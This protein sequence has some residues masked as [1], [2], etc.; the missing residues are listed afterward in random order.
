[1][2]GLGKIGGPQYQDGRGMLFAEPPRGP[3]GATMA[4]RRGQQK[5]Y[6]H[7]QGNA[8]YLAYREDALDAEGK[9]VRVRRN[10]RIADT[11]EVSKREAQRIAREILTRVDEQAQRPNS[12]VTVAEFIEGRFKPD[13]V[14]ALK[15]AGQKHYD[16]ILTKHV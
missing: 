10:Q 15:H 3:S 1:M 13:V 12:L 11:K 9:I 16:Y 6:V 5:G 7:K 8:W 2:G 4:R 14:W